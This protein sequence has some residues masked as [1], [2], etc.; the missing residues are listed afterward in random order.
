M[1]EYLTKVQQ[2]DKKKNSSFLITIPKVLSNI[3]EISKGSMISCSLAKLPDSNEPIILMKKV[4][5]VKTEPEYR[6]NVVT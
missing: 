5:E 1:L 6:V 3:L 4:K 2:N